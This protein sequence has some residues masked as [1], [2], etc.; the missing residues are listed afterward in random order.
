M[1]HAVLKDEQSISDADIPKYEKSEILKVHYSKI[2]TKGKGINKSDKEEEF[3]IDAFKIP[4]NILKENNLKLVSKGEIVEDSWISLQ[5]LASKE[6]VKGFKYL[7][8][9]SGNYIDDR[10]TNLRGELNI[11][12]KDSF[13]KSLN[14][15]SNEEVLLDDIQEEV[16]NKINSMYPEIEEVKKQHD[17]Q[18]ER[19]KEMFN[20]GPQTVK[21][22]DISI[23]DSE[24]KILESS[25]NR[26]LKKPHR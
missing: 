2:P 18:L 6:N 10:D 14:A 23:D 1:F 22:I 21:D 17:E 8:L 12:T 24:S 20:L 15:F 9:V 7:F 25:M 3:T 26:R 13:T 5:S 11:P 16:N 19:L 4:T